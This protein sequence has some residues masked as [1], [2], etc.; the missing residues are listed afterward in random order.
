MAPASDGEQ[1]FFMDYIQSEQEVSGFM[2]TEFKGP[3]R[4]ISGSVLKVQQKG[5]SW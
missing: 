3:L 5:E 1:T 4:L 2:G